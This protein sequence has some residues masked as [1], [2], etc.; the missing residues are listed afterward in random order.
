MWVEMRRVRVGSSAGGHGAGGAES[1]GGRRNA[2]LRFLDARNHV[3]AL[4][5]RMYCIDAVR[6][7][8]FRSSIAPI[9][10]V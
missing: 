1:R 3:E 9:A 8:A 6:L 4:Q 10:I 7:L 5:R 2:S